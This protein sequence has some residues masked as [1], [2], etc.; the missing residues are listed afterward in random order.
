MQ[1][2][3]FSPFREKVGERRKFL[4]FT[5]GSS[6]K[7]YP[8]APSSSAVDHGT[9]SFPF[10]RLVGQQHPTQA[11]L[12]VGEQ[13]WHPWALSFPVSS[14]SPLLRGGRLCWDPGRSLL[15]ASLWVK[16]EIQRER[17]TTQLRQKQVKLSS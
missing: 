1:E 4:P 13:K 10:P 12:A 3:G 14:Q 6:S 11:A 9:F 7:R 5:A 8:E 16:E 17:S 2:G 15:R